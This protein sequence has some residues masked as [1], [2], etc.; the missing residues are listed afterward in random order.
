[1]MQAPDVYEVFEQHNEALTNLG[2][3]RKS[4]NTYATDDGLNLKLIL[5]PWGWTEE[6]GWGFLMRLTDVAAPQDGHPYQPSFDIRTSTLVSEGRVSQNMIEDIYKDYAKQHP[7]ILDGL[8]LGWF[9]FYDATHLG[10]ILDQFLP[11]VAQAAKDWGSKRIE[12]RKKPRP[13]Y[14]KRTQEEIKAIREKAEKDLKHS[15]FKLELP[16]EK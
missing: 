14:R 12:E 15:G 10:R 6:L 3:K 9:T 5:N 13:P 11:A 7:G 2:F 16:G 8:E 4:R 1:M